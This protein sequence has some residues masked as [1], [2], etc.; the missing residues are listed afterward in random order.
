MD[1]LLIRRTPLL[2]SERPSAG[3]K[4]T[5]K[6]VFNVFNEPPSHET[7]CSIL[8]RATLNCTI[9]DLDTFKSQVNVL[10]RCKY[11]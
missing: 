2:E 5:R 11:L 6:R 4:N 8:Q 9:E 7:W 3:V 10:G 1:G